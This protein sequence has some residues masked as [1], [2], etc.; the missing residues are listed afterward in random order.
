MDKLLLLV[1]SVLPSIIIALLIYK[2]DKKEREPKKELIKSFLFG[3]LSVILTLLLSF[4]FKVVD[5]DTENANMMEIFIYSFVSIAFVEELSK[6]LCSY[7]FLRKNKEYNYIFDGIVYCVYVA[8]GFATVENIL[9]TLDSGIVI[10]LIRAISTV[11]AHAFF[12]VTCGYYYSLYKFDKV[13]GKKNN[14]CLFLSLAVPTIL[15]GFYDFCLF[16]GNY[17]LVITYIV[18]VVV[19]YVSSIKKIKHMAQIDKPL[20]KE[21]IYV[22]IDENNNYSI[23]EKDIEE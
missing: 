5:F 21:E 14:K 1:I 18:F 17:L 20:E 15:H 6:W 11:P 16:S 23:S 9:Y 10:G 2:A 7:L 12:G 4:A 19:L 22:N 3:I 8:L 13:N